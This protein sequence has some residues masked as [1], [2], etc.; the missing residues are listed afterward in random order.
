[1]NPLPM[2][3]DDDAAADD[4]GFVVDTHR[5]RFVAL[6]IDTSDSMRTTETDGVPAIDALNRR[7]AA[8]LP[9]VRAEGRGPLRDVEFVVLTF[10]AGGVV[11]VSGDGKRSA[12][13]EGAFVPSARLHIPELVAGG[14]TPMVEAVDLALHL[15]EERRALVQRL[16]QQTGAPRL[17]LISDGAPTDPEGNPTGEWRQLARRL[18]QSRRSRRTQLF[19]FGV[20]GVDDEVMRALATD[21]GYFK[22]TELDLKKLLDLVLVATAE[23][24]DFADVRKL[25]AEEFEL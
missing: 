19:A 2:F 15:L 20:P 18:E 21:D 11:V 24:T 7:I 8:W 17:V 25:F 5:R 23:H 13:D 6:L 1:M 22:L 12:D 10:G 4:V 14:A 3:D 9:K 16:G